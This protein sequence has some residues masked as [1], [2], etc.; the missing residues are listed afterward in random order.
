MRRL[1]TNPLGRFL[2]SISPS[3]LSF[4]FLDFKI[5]DVAQTSMKLETGAKRHISREDN[6]VRYDIGTDISEPIER[7]ADDACRNGQRLKSVP[8]ARGADPTILQTLYLKRTY[9]YVSIFLVWTRK[10]QTGHRRALFG[11][12]TELVLHETRLVPFHLVSPHV[13]ENRIEAS[14]ILEPE[15]SR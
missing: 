10:S 9:P 11:S 5:E 15:K 1:L 8:T 13:L 7:L 12:E 4:L 6:L 3:E 14:S 2:S